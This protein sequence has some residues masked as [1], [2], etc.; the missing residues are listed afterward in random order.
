MPCIVASTGCWNFGG[1]AALSSYSFFNPDHQCE[2][3]IRPMLTAL[4]IVDSQLSRRTAPR[5]SAKNCALSILANHR[6]NLGLW[7]AKI[8]I[9]LR[10]H[11]FPQNQVGSRLI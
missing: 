9:C 11:Q 1:S 10:F 7:L 8:T 3:M 5:K 2:T 4:Q 6:G